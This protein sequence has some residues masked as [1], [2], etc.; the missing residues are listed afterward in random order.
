[1]ARYRVLSTILRGG[2]LFTPE[3]GDEIEL[4]DGEVAA[5]R[6]AGAIDPTPIGGVRTSG[7]A[8]PTKAAPAGGAGADG[9]PDRG[10]ED[11]ASDRSGGPASEESGAGSNG[12]PAPPTAHAPTK[13]KG[14]K[15][16]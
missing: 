13:R 9:V 11:R 6:D 16:G 5:L 12:E 15:G 10:S 4:A 1:M 3:D 14:R 2:K 7:G 8:S